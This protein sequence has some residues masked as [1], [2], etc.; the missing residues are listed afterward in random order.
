[1]LTL[2]SRSYFDMKI[3]VKRVKINQNPYGISISY[4]ESSIENIQH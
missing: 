2:K 4:S 1:M 3:I